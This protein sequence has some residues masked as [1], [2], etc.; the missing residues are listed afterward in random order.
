MDDVDEDLARARLAGDPHIVLFEATAAIERGDVEGALARLPE[1]EALGTVWPRWAASIW[2][3]IRTPLVAASGQARDVAALRASMEGVADT[4]AVLGGV[5]TV[6][7]P[8]RHWLGVLAAA[9]G[10]VDDAIDAFDAAA[11]AARRLRAPVWETLAEVER[12][13]L[14]VSRRRPRDIEEAKRVLDA[15]AASAAASRME[16]VTRRLADLRRQVDAASNDQAGS[17]EGRD[18]AVFRRDGDVWTLGFDGTTVGMPDSKGLA[19]IHRLICNPGVE[20]AA[21]ELVHGSGEDVARAKS[22]LGADPMLDEAAR[23]AYRTRLESLEE[24]IDAALARNR[25]DLA[26]S[27]EAERMAIIGELASATGLGGR[28]R[29]LGDDAE[30]ARKTVTARIRDALRRLDDRH[31]ALAAHLRASVT[32]GNR[33]RYQPQRMRDW[34]T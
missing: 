22:L 15:L 2:W 32:T 9:S 16:Q 21:I 6:W 12:A 30:K 11:T 13:A 27:L 33:C 20:I 10:D 23:R 25:D 24:E 34:D 17:V 1:I 14:L 4:W 28:D 31:P 26:S 8:I 18:L 5:V 29:R 3:S 7:G 19:D